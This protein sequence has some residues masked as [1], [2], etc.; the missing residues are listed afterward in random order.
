[1]WDDVFGYAPK[2]NQQLSLWLDQCCY[3]FQ[4]IKNDS[5]R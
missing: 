2:D 1:M 5:A 3:R 4:A